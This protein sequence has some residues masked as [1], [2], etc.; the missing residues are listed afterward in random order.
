M[1]P[2]FVNIRYEEANYFSSC[3][4]FCYSD[5]IPRYSGVDLREDKIYTIQ[6]TLVR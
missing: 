4:P 2:P 5:L 6:G 1:L 3:A